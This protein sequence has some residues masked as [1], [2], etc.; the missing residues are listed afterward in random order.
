MRFCL[1]DIE[2]VDC[3]SLL[4]IFC[5]LICY[6]CVA[7]FVECAVVVVMGGCRCC[8]V[9]GCLIGV[10]CVVF[11]FFVYDVCCLRDVN[12]CFLYCCSLFVF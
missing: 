6:I 11:V 12:C 1:C 8:C 9:C 10:V 3:W 7:F 2:L 5:G 4:Y